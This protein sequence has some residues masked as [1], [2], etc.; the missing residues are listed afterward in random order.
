MRLVIGQGVVGEQCCTFDNWVLLVIGLE[1]QSVAP[2][3]VTKCGLSVPLDRRTSS[4]C[5]IKSRGRRGAENP[6]RTVLR[7]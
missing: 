5:A 7:V 4:A 1:W 2:G 3:G 6:A